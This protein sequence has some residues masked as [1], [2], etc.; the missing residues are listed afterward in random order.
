MVM[1]TR[2]TRRHNLLF[3]ILLYTGLAFLLVGLV[4]V[5]SGHP[6]LGGGCIVTWLVLLIGAI[7]VP[8][9]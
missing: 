7:S 6:R 5:T 1:S 9:R 2:A 8:D 4:A 3:R